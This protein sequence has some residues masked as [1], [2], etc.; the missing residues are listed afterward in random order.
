MSLHR[1]QIAP[2]LSERSEPDLGLQARET[3]A[4]R[5]RLTQ[6]SRGIP[7]TGPHARQHSE[8]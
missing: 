1:R 6:Y 4:G 3:A 7:A 2:R 8:T 5:E